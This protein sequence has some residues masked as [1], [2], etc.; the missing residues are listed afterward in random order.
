[1]VDWNYFDSFEKINEKYLP[2]RG[3]GESK[4][5]QIVTAINRLI[6]KW[7]N[8]GDVFDNTHGMKGWLNDVSDCANWLDKNT[9]E[10]AS[11]ILHR[12]YECRNDDEYEEILKSLAD[13]LLDEAYLQEQEKIKKEGSVYDCAGVFKFIDRS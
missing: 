5:T 4:A 10:E 12:I 13:T 7:Y 8:D 2:P 6:Y 9:K 11:E 3:E 1:M